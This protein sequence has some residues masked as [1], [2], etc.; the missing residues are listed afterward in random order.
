ALALGAALALLAGGGAAAAPRAS[1]DLVEVVVTLPRPSLATAIGHDRT[2]ATAATRH[3][4]S[5]A[6]RAPAAVFYLRTLAAAQRTL[7][8]R[9]AVAIPAA[10]VRLHYGVAL[11]G[12]SVVL[13][14]AEV[15][16][17]RTLPGATVWPTVT[18]HA[19]SAPDSDTTT[20]ADP[21][22]AL[23]G[24]PELWG[25]SL[26]TAGQGIK[27]GLVDDGID[28]AHPYFNPAG[29]A[30][31]SGFPKGNTAYTTPKVIVA[32]AFPSPSTHWKYADKPF[33]PAFSF[34][35][36]HVAGIAAGDHDTPTAPDNGSPI[37]GVAPKA[38]LGNYKAL[39]VPTA[40]YGLDGNSPEI[41]KAI[42]QAV[43]DG[44]NVI[45]LS[46]GEPEVEPRRDI[47]VKA[48][49]NAAAAGVVPVVS[50][51][52]DFDAAGYGS[53]GSPANAPAAITAAAST[54]GGDGTQ[55]DH[56][57]SFSSGG[58]TPLSLLLKPDVTAPGVDVLSSIPAHDFETLDGTSMAAPHVSG[59]AALLLQRHPTWT[60]QQVKS[61]LASTGDTVHPT[62]H[63]G[64]VSVL[65]EGGGRIDLVRADHPLLLTNPTSLGW[66]LVRRGFSGAKELS[67]AD[68]GGGSEPWTVSIHTQSAPRG[69]KLAPEKTSLVAGATLA[70]QLT[71]SPTAEAGDGTGFVI[72][73]RGSDVRRIAFWFHVEVPRL[74]L[75]PHRTLRSAGVYH[76]DTAGQPSRVSSYRYPEQGLA[77]T[78]PTRLGGP[79][80]VFRFTLRRQVANFGVV[81]T[82]HERGVRV[83]PRLVAGEDENRVVGY[84]GIPASLNPYQG[85]DTAEPVVGAVLPDPGLYEFVF[86]TPTGAKPGA[87]TFRF[88]VND[89]SP[90]SIRLLGRKHVIGRPLRLAVHDSGSGVDPRSFHARVGGKP[91]RL[92]YSGGVLYLRTKGLRPGKK[93]LV[94]T[95]SDYQETKNMEDVGPVLPNTRTVRTRV[96][97]RR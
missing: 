74:G 22:P 75:D 43:A 69:A 33:D 29:Y 24:A 25:P 83:S 62:G 28:Q 8:A 1:A 66:G 34:H 49:D 54:M 58:P 30:Y 18:Y 4:H 35:A 86:D 16:R 87:F 21:G 26:A 85:F 36:T 47:V 96:T 12:V 38:Y 40:D 71:V 59:A 91:V 81:V 2:L 6:V 44:M 95:A 55:P 93:A 67:T 39:T 9:L 92:R 70:L 37:S 5:L 17:L 27:I 80:Q 72:L 3:S 61:A 64:A 48:L 50:A 57:A 13:P 52:N 78:V 63:S 60:V 88:W 89:T 20:S 46:I 10:R 23:I 31:P 79:E 45:N 51:G 53:V 84:T 73:T 7:G 14:S 68:A 19:L 94:V 82:G 32:R 90:P 76:G 97:L 11:D 56:I 42:D 77:P 65:R 41:A 15:A